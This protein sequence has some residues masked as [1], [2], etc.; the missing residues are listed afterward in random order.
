MAD[1]TGGIPLE[2]TPVL[3]VGA[4]MV[5]MTLS[6]L[7]AKHGVQ[8]CIAVEKHAG[9]AIHPRAAL[10][11]P[12]TMQIYREL[13]LYDAMCEES[14]K[15]YD[16][17]AGIVDV[18]SLAGKFLR[19]WMSNMNEG[20][21]DL[22]PTVRLFLTQQMFEPILRAKVVGDGVDLRF[23]TEMVEFQQD[24]GGVTALLRNTETGRKTLVRA[25]YMV[26]CEGNRSSTRSKLGIEIKGHGL[27]SHSI[28]IYFQ[29]DLGKYVKGKYNGVIYVNNPEVRGFFRL[30]KWVIV[31][32][33]TFTLLIMN[34]RQKW[35][36]RISRRL[37][38]RPTRHRGKPFP[39]R[40]H[41]RRESQKITTCCHWCG[42]RH[43]DHPHFAMESC[44]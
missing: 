19:S 36:R 44:V 38:R 25:R 42:C 37:H 2:H 11:H 22:S 24:A 13:G 10:F 40:R 1:F 39:S 33:D 15:H 18:E 32:F 6:A 20:I 29:A 28:T 43:R 26:A 17:H 23:S 9:T 12:R 4:S 34:T 35:H 21:E 14:S 16:Q 7:L 5:G 8:G 27:L 30:G 41:H 3:V 31:L